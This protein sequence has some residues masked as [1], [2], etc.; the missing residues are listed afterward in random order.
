[1]KLRT[2][3]GDHRFI[4]GMLHR[5]ASRAPELQRGGQ[6]GGGSD[7]KRT[8]WKERSGGVGRVGRVH[9][10][11]LGE[12]NRPKTPGNGLSRPR[13]PL[14]FFICVFQKHERGSEAAHT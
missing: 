5:G 6:L 8:G 4:A 2:T 9:P 3:A 13:N 10:G 1:M 7:R 12:K 11:D 14:A